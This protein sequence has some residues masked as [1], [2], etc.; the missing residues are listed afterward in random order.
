MVEYRPMAR[1]PKT[2]AELL[3]DHIYG[4]GA[5]SVKDFSKKNK[6]K[7]IPSIHSLRKWVEGTLPQ[8]VGIE[9]NIEF[10]PEDIRK[11][12]LDFLKEEW[13]GKNLS[14]TNPYFTEI[15]ESKKTFSEILRNYLDDNKIPY[16]KKTSKGFFE[17]V[18]KEWQCSNDIISQAFSLG[19]KD[20][21]NYLFKKNKVSTHTM[22]SMRILKFSKE[23]GKDQLTKVHTL[24]HKD[25]LDLCSLMNGNRALGEI[26]GI[27]E[28]GIDAIIKKFQNELTGNKTVEERQNIGLNAY[29]EVLDF[30]GINSVVMNKIAGEGQKK[31][32]G[33][34]EKKGPYAEYYSGTMKFNN[35]IA[36][37]NPSN[38]R[39]IAKTLFKHDEKLQN[40]FANLLVGIRKYYTK[41]ELYNAILNREVQM[42]EAFFIARFQ[43]GKTRQ[44]MAKDLDVNYTRY[45]GKEIN[46]QEYFHKDMITN[47]AKKFLDIKDEGKIDKLL[48]VNGLWHAEFDPGIIKR[49][50]EG[51]WEHQQGWKFSK[52]SL[53][54]E[55]GLNMLLENRNAGIPQISRNVKGLGFL[56]IKSIMETGILPDGITDSNKYKYLNQLA[57]ALGVTEEFK[58]RFTEV[59]FD[60][61]QEIKK[62]NPVE[63]PSSE[64]TKISRKKAKVASEIKTEASTSFVI[65]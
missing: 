55:Q 21:K 39:K 41:D 13:V 32:A 19:N 49:M 6:G 22:S 27:K 57:I 20:V 1:I 46:G 3:E 17:N 9:K 62:T 51:L 26:N 36:L 12:A 5:V 23:L 30:Y 58:T 63:K 33:E 53:T 47:F 50:K 44:E 24:G 54:A 4:T 65:E 31:D 61:S 8:A 60:W 2:F 16:S 28:T 10:L 14:T 18:K 56:D 42:N 29:K 64:T 45:A 7:N 35:L 11:Q 34:E 40:A 48:H 38:V 15:I 25:F 37:Q 43:E 52:D 59:L